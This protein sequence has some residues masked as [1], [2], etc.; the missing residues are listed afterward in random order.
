[1]PAV[2]VA[3][4]LSIASFAVLYVLFMRRI[5]NELTT[6]RLLD[7]LRDEVNS[8]VVELNQ[9]TDR[10]VGLVEERI[11]RLQNLIS[12]TDKRIQL[13]GREMEKHQVGVDVYEKLKR[14]SQRMT[15]PRGADTPV[16]G[17][18]ASG[19]RA[20]SGT[21]IGR[22]GS[23]A[24]APAADGAAANPSI[25]AGESSEPSE[26]S[27]TLSE[28]VMRLANQ[29]FDARIIAQKLGSTLGEVE[30]ILSLKHD[31]DGRNT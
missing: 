21:D 27:G 28:R 9:T 5:K 26:S 24:A 12:E 14:S 22:N 2:I 8:L 3:V 20:E 4:L 11:K 31:R 6:R 16:S 29:G 7:E 10:N 23:E 1:M 15:F 19:N 13:L 25:E 18:V 17:S 30:L